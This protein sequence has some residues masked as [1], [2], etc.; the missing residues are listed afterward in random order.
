MYV[1]CS[2]SCQPVLVHPSVHLTVKS[3]AWIFIKFSSSI[4]FGHWTNQTLVIA[5]RVR[6]SLGIN[7]FVYSRMIRVAM[8]IHLEGSGSYGSTRES[9]TLNLD[10][11]Q[12]GLQ[13]DSLLLDLKRPNLTW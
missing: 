8:A 6:G 9:T 5:L 3:C 11:G 7:C 13:F 4:D 1:Q 12:K 2:T 10:D